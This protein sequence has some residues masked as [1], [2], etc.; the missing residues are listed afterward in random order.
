MHAVCTVRVTLYSFL[1]LLFLVMFANNF[2]IMKPHFILVLTQLV[3]VLTKNN[4]YIYYI[5]CIVTV[6]TTMQSMLASDNHF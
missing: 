6:G 3:G 2:T 1:T 5:P 4:I